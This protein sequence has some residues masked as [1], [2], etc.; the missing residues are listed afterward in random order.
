MR[1]QV[2]IEKLAKRYAQ[3]ANLAGRGKPSAERRMNSIRKILDSLSLGQQTAVL[4]IANQSREE[5]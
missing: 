1:T 3:A 2:Q 5:G 4:L